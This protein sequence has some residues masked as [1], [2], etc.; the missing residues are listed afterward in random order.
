MTTAVLID[1]AGGIDLY[2]NSVRLTNGVPTSGYVVNGDWQWRIVGGE[3][4]AC[5]RG[6]RKIVNRW[7]KRVY[8]VVMPAPRG[9]D[10]NEVIAKAREP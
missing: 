1:E 3:E 10:Y 9:R 8:R 5:V 4:L 7:P 2:L 6:T